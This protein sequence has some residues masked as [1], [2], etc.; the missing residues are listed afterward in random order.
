VEILEVYFEAYFGSL[1]E[2]Q[3]V[4]VVVVVLEVEVEVGVGVVVSLIQPFLKKKIE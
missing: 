3:L 1:V 2:V 4:F